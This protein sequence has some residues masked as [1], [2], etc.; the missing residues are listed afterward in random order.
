MTRIVAF[1]SL[2]RI[3]LLCLLLALPACTSFAAIQPKP[4]A[5]AAE[6]LAAKPL[7]NKSVDEKGNATSLTALPK[8]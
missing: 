3:V 7:P 2:R 6:E 5:L 4:A 1:M 8:G